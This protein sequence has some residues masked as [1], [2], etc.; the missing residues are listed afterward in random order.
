M[1]FL[2]GRL[3][4]GFLREQVYREMR[5]SYIQIG[6]LKRIGINLSEVNHICGPQLIAMYELFLAWGNV[7]I[8]F[9]PASATK[10][11]Q[12]WLDCDSDTTDLYDLYRKSPYS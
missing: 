11:E 1:Y 4:C 12:V 6:P 5:T 2:A 8:D 9:V 3:R 10:E 7:N